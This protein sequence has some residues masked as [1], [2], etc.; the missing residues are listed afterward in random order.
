MWGWSGLGQ[1]DKEHQLQTERLEKY[2]NFHTQM[3]KICRLGW[4]NIENILKS[5][6]KLQLKSI[7][8]RIWFINCFEKWLK[9]IF[10]LKYVM[11]LYLSSIR[12]ASGSFWPKL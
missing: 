4:K 7:N 11:F 10:S 8:S 12:E 3:K 6:K 9:I 1:Q 5:A 2:E